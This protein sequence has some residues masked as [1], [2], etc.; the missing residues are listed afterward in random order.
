MA[1]VV[2][3]H[4]CMVLEWWTVMQLNSK[5]LTAQ[6]L[7]IPDL[8]SSSCGIGFGGAKSW[9]FNFKRLG[10]VVLLK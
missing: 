2:D 7:N 1:P 4:I 5:G 10:F 9:W 3:A 6:P 8:P